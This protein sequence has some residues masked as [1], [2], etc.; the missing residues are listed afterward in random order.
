MF[1]GYISGMMRH[2]TIFVLSVTIK[3]DQ[4]RYKLN[5]LPPTYVNTQMMIRLPEKIGCPVQSEL[6]EYRERAKKR[7]MAKIFGGRASSKHEC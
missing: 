7:K 3:S 2:K 1:Q 5:K 6:K 4:N